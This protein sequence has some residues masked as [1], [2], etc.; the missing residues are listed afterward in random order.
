MDHR[1]LLSSASCPSKSEAPPPIQRQLMTNAPCT[2]T[3]CSIWSLMVNNVAMGA[4][5]LQCMDLQGRGGGGQR[6]ELPPGAPHTQLRIDF[7]V[8]CPLRRLPQGRT[9]TD[10]LGSH[11]GAHPQCLWHLQARIP[12]IPS[13]PL[14]RWALQ[15]LPTS[16]THHQTIIFILQRYCGVHIAYCVRPCSA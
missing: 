12:T 3:I 10:A 8:A 5:W 2:S 14:L 15:Q 9:S 4:R 13:H 7:H 6:P 1:R 16:G 11:G